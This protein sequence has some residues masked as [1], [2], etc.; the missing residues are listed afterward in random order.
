MSLDQQGLMCSGCM[1]TKF[2]ISIAVYLDPD[3]LLI[4]DAL[5]VGNLHFQTQCRE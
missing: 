1:V 2:S 5:M 3:A 4:D